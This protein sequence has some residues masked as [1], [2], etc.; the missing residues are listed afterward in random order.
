M[1][2]F[3]HSAD[4]H[5]ASPFKG[6]R[7]TNPEVGEILRKATFD[8]YDRLIRLCVDKKVDALLVAGD[9]FDG[10]TRDVPAQLK[11]VQGLNA[12]KAK[13]IQVFLCHGNHDPLDE[14]STGLTLPDNV[15]QFREE[16]KCVRVNDSQNSPVVCGISYPTR[17]V[18]QSLLNKFPKRDPDLFTIG[19]LHANV[20]ANSDHDPYAPCT[21]EELTAS[22]YDYWALGHVHSRD[23][24][25][26][27]NPMIVYPG[28]TQGRHSKETGPRGVYVVE[29]DEEKNIS[30]EEFVAVDI[31]RWERWS[32]D[33]SGVES[34]E[35]LRPHLDSRIKDGLNSIDGRHLVCCLRLTGRTHLY[36]QL[37]LQET[38]DQLIEALNLLWENKR[39]FVFCGDI[40]NSTSSALDLES[41]RQGTDFNGEFLKFTQN[42]KNNPDVLNI[43]LEDLKPLFN[44]LQL[45]QQ[46]EHLEPILRTEA[47]ARALIEDAEGIALNLLVEEDG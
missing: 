46:H 21:V 1:F 3:I 31:V 42:L 39:P 28:N 43:L 34:L 41:V 18:E 14:W 13:D 19:L 40:K 35:D 45:R 11:F 25:Q 24:K 32:V 47:D 22:G 37:A 20:G 2:R 26:K 8:A 5:L 17:K 6:L 23:I 7:K 38:I 4:L 30:R 12:L 36:K 9:V 29:V 16:A 10:A 15:H 33:V 44:L 27:R